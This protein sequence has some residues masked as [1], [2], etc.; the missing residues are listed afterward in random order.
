ME[1]GPGRLHGSHFPA[2]PNPHGDEDERC[3]AALNEDLME[4]GFHREFVRPG[5]LRVGIPDQYCVV[6]FILRGYSSEAAFR[7]RDV[8]TVQLKGVRWA[9][10]IL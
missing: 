2:E 8:Q 1:K 6:T 4:S 5:F 9:V 7:G 10:R 3:V